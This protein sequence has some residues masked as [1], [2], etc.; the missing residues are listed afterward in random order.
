MLE[1]V[2]GYADDQNTRFRK[3]MEDEH[4]VVP[5][6]ASR[7]LFCGLY[8]GHGGRLAV[9]FVKEQLH[10]IAER[11][12]LSGAPGEAPLEAMK[13]AFLKVDRM[14]LPIGAVN[15]GTTC[16]VCLCLRGP[17][18]GSPLELHVANTGDTRVV[19]LSDG[20]APARRLSVDHVAT[21]PDEVRRV[22]LSGGHVMGNRVGGTLAVTRALG[23]HVLK[24][25]DGGVT[26]EPHCVVYRVGPADRFVIMAS[27]GVWDVMSDDDVQQL[28]LQ[29]AERPL[30]EI[31][32]NVVQA[33][34]QFG[35]RD[36][37]SALVVR[38]R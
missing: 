9:E 8:D 35:S 4:M 7:G 33:A 25:S 3:Y 17:S 37:L 11:E 22:Q 18:P 23:D 14:L 27:D 1:L 19:L 30:D 24:G 16:A 5:N 29:H 36:N 32:R 2:H 26:A 20:S 28:V 34:K 10:Q 21:D 6:F 31:S 12:L 38:L 13:R 15:C